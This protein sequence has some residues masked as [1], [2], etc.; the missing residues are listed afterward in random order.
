MNWELAYRVGWH[1]WEDALGQ[2][3][4]MRRIAALLEREERGREPPFGLA[5]DLGCG[6]GIWG[7]E[8]ARRGWQV[9]GVDLVKKALV[10]GEHRVR[11]A[12]VDVRLVQ[13]DVTELRASGVG[14]GYRLVLDTG[15]FH[16]LTDVQRAAM[17]REVE[18][19]SASDATVLLIAWTP[20]HRGPLPR[21]V[22]AEGIGA[23]FG[24]WTVADEGPSGFEAPKP[25]ERL[26]RPDERWYRLQRS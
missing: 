11:D 6:S 14:D 22:T 15:T 12:G 8:L 16:D 3:G 25:I 5:L 18:A 2:A 13:G 4:F 21:G 19:I 23:A 9:T 20:R 24:G 1:P 26:L 10:R 17:G 7:I